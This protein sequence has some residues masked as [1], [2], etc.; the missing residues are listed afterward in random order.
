MITDHLV[1][2][3]HGPIVSWIGTRNEKFRPTVAWVFGAKV[4]R[5]NDRITVFAP[6]T[7]L[8]QT[9]R[10][11]EQNGMVAY[12]CADGLT[13]ESYQ[14]KGNM[15]ELRETTDEER[16]IQDIHMSKWISYFDGVYPDGLTTGY[17]AHPSTAVTFQVKEIFVQ[18]P[19]PDAGEQIHSPSATT[20]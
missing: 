16:A 13:H 3:V 5:E 12:T 10:N 17:V 19:G 7:E 15:I 4:D 11:L 18:T 1:D 2:F 9:Q 8:D 6:N 14:F 20:D